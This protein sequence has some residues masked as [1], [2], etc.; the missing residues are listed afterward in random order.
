MWEDVWTVLEFI[1]SYFLVG[2]IGGAV[3]F[4][5]PVLTQWLREVIARRRK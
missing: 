1:G 5:V 3:F 4:G 2:I